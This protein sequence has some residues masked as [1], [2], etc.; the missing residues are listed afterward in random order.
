MRLKIRVSNALP[1]LMSAAMWFA[2]PAFAQSDEASSHQQHALP[3]SAWLGSYQG[4]LP[5][6]DCQGV[7]TT[8]ALNKNQSYM[9]MTVYVGRS[10]REFVEKG[11]FEWVNNDTIKLIPKNGGESRLYA[12]NGN[13]LTQLDNSGQ[14]VS[15]K[16]AE[17]YNLRRYDVTQTKPSHKHH[18]GD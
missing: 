16:D 10:D 8:L 6:A 7:K 4:F 9:S 5:C 12:F 18:P 15:G 17:R 13:T 1:L 3:E 11:K 14:R 2:V